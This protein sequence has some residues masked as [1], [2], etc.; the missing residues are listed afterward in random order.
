[1]SNI[2]IICLYYVSIKLSY[3]LIINIFNLFSCKTQTATVLKV[4]VIYILVLIF[5]SLIYDLNYIKYYFVSSSRITVYNIINL[6][7]S[8]CLR[9]T[10]FWLVVRCL[11]SAFS[12]FVVPMR[13]T[14]L[15]L[16]LM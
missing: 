2:T 8:H 4:I 14:N 11:R 13:K 12:Y 1:M 16:F 6:M 5:N 9:S 3:S 15:V 7:K 10:N